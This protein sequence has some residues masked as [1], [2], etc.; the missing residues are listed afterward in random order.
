MKICVLGAGTWGMALAALL[1]K[2]RHDV[3]V[4][5][6]LPNEIDEL[7][8]NGIHKNLPGIKLSKSIKYT[9]DIK[10]AAEGKEM[11]LLVVPSSF[12]RSTTY[13]LAP[14]IEDGTILVTAAKG[15]ECGSLM[16]MTEIISDELKTLRP[17]LKYSLGALSGPTHAEEVAL[18]MPTSI[19][20]ACD[21]EEISARI[22]EVFA[23]SC[24]RVYTNNDV[25]GVEICGAM[26]N[27]IALAAGINNG[28]GLGDNSKAMLM[29]RG[30]AEISRLGVA[31]GGQSHTFSG[32][33]G[34]GD[35]IVTCIS[36][37]SRNRR[38]GLLVGG[39]M[40]VEQA[41]EE[42]GAVVEGYFATRAVQELTRDMNLDMPICQAMYA[43]LVEQKPLEDVVQTLLGR[44]K[45]AEQDAYEA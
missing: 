37:H 12:I 18:G 41:L 34:V 22:A 27:I 30:I 26:K 42:V 9:K 10:A 31:L 20:S 2:N 3:T 4:W 36:N 25:R 32:L 24:M 16:T 23:N 5:S 35:L 7:E 45:R 38:F 11:I 29:T 19:V 13:N 33:S 8:K 14:Y 6:A 43:I 39:G 21:D 15:I 28:M 1:E 17:D 40:P 44:A